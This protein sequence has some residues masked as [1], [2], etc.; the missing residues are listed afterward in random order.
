AIGLWYRGIP[1]KQNVVDNM[2]RDAVV[3]ILGFQFE[4]IEMGYSY[5]FTVSELGAISGGTHE[6]SLQYKLDIQTQTR[7]KKKQR[8]IPCPTFNKR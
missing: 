6:V 4:K 2:S 1:I 7:S 3:V 5:D 8:Y